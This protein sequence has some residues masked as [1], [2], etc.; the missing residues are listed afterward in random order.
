MH[1]TTV[2]SDCSMQPSVQLKPNVNLLEIS[3][4]SQ[5]PFRGLLREST[6]ISSQVQHSK[7]ADLRNHVCSDNQ[8]TRVSSFFKTLRK[9]D[10]IFTNLSF[11]HL[12]TQMH[13]TTVRPN[14]QLKPNLTYLAIPSV[15]QS[16]VPFI[17]L[18]KLMKWKSSTD[19]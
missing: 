12:D 1:I 10:V 4:N 3:H 14:V 15:P 9:L 8:W 17:F 5:L 13:T 6:T 19:N 16:Y 7:Q 11:V 18:I 2:H